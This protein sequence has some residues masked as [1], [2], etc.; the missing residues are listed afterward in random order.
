MRRILVIAVMLGLVAAV[1]D[2]KNENTIFTNYRLNYVKLVNLGKSEQKDLTP[3]HPAQITVAKMTEMLSSIRLSRRVFFKSKVEDRGAFDQGAVE[4]LSPYLVE[5]FKQA[6]P[7]QVVAFS[8]LFKSPHVLARND[9]FT[10][11]VA[12]VKDNQLHIEFQK[13]FARLTADLDKRG[14]TS[15]AI[16]NSRGLRIELETGPGQ[17]LGANN[18][19][20][21]VLDTGATFATVQGHPRPETTTQRMEELD[22]LKAMKLITPEEYSAKRQAIINKL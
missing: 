16:S 5:A 18:P 2:A 17:M 12:W 15:R 21:I 4:T 13:L 14:Y 11:G 10:T 20:E 7:N 3:T 22:R 1:A 9:R 6:K 19:R 8:Y